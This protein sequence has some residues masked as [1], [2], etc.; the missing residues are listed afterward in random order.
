MAKM[1]AERGEAALHQ[2]SLGKV[3][4]KVITPH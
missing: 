2:P 3:P 1:L 4:E